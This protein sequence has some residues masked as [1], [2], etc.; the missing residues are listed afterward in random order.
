M[1]DDKI[2]EYAEGWAV[3]ADATCIHCKHKWVAVFPVGAILSECP[4]CHKHPSL[5]SIDDIQSK[6]N[7]NV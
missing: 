1:N 5:I 7:D 6:D 2:I 4:R 3:N